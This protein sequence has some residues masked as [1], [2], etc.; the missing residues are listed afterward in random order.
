M[1]GDSLQLGEQIGACHCHFTGKDVDVELRIVQM[2]LD[3]CHGTV[4]NLLVYGVGGKHLYKGL[5]LLAELLLQ[6]DAR[7]HEVVAARNQ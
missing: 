4:Q 7:V 6:E 2:L 3:D 5:R 1:S